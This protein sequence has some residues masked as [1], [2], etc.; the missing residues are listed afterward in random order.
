M[1]DEVVARGPGD[2]REECQ[3]GYAR[4]R[5]AAAV[6]PEHDRAL[7]C[8][9]VRVS[10]EDH[11]RSKEDTDEY[12]H[13]I[14]LASVM[15]YSVALYTAVCDSDYIQRFAICQEVILKK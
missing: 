11:C 15:I 7:P 3:Q 5:P 6:L 4:D 13:L 14:A 8:A 9:Y 12:F 1:L 2:Q 10:R